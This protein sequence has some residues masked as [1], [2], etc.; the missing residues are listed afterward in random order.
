MV[1][2]IGL[3]D[4]EIEWKG[5]LILSNSVLLP[6]GFPAFSIPRTVRPDAYTTPQ[7]TSSRS[8]EA[9]HTDCSLAGRVPPAKDDHCRK[10][11]G[12]NCPYGGPLGPVALVTLYRGAVVF[13]KQSD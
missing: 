3:Q 4:R 2:H 6:E 9:V 1:I 10:G 12:A 7:Y 13:F 5:N 8:A 11:T